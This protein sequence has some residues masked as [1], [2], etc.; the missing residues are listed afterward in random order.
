MPD[1]ESHALRFPTDNGMA[2]W[3]ATPLFLTMAAAWLYA[4]VKKWRQQRVLILLLPLLAL[5]HVFVICCHRTLGGWH[6]GNRYLLDLL[7][8]LFYGLLVWK[9]D[10]DWFAR[11]NMPLF[12]LGLSMQLIGTAAVY[13]HWM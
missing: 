13:N 2:F 11:W 3:L 4:V 5:L 12:Y 10:E 6:F 7:P 9:P 8:Y 1:P